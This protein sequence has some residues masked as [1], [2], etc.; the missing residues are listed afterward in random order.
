MPECQVGRS[1]ATPGFFVTLVFVV[2]LVKEIYQLIDFFRAGY[3]TLFTKV[4]LPTC[5]GPISTITLPLCNFASTTLVI[6]LFI[7]ALNFYKDIHKNS[8]HQI[9]MIIGE[10][11]HQYYIIFSAYIH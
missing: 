4:V 5:R 3:K 2:L 10:Y 1:G 6:S 9:Y 8:I 7:I 11:I